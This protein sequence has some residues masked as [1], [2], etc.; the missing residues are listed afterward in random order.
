M[1]GETLPSLEGKRGQPLPRL[2]PLL[3]T[4]GDF[5][6]RGEKACVLGEQLLPAVIGAYTPL[7]P[8][9]QT[10]GPR[11]AGAERILYSHLLGN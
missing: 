11:R 3:E 2:L 10:A 8:G 7:T 9:P 6:G 1:E 5:Q 4:S